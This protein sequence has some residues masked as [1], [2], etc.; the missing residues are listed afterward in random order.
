MKVFLVLIAVFIVAGLV[1]SNSPK[2]G[3]TTT[4]LGNSNKSPQT[5]SASFG[6][7]TSSRVDT[8]TKTPIPTAVPKTTPTP[9]PTKSARGK[10]LAEYVPSDPGVVPASGSTYQGGGV[11]ELA[12][13]LP[14]ATSVAVSGDGR[15]LDQPLPMC[16][17]AYPE[18]RTC[19]PYG[20]PFAQGCA[21]TPERNFT[22]LP[23]D[24][25][26]LDA[27]GDGIGCEPIGGSSPPVDA[28]VSASGPDDRPCNAAYPDVCIPAGPPYLDC[29][30]V[31]YLWGYEDFVVYPPDPQNFDGDGDGWG[32]EPYGGQQA[33]QSDWEQDFEEA[34]D[35]QREQ[36]Y[37]DYLDDQA[38][39]DDY[40]DDYYEEQ[41]DPMDY[42]DAHR[43]ME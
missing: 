32:C 13:S 37:Q 3:L 24:P 26:G 36:E 7:G 14:E 8:A 27:D 34:R 39:R 23:P 16:D 28:P 40:D 12:A 4:G 35:A 30:D 22:V 21:I 38:L 2:Q 43:C 6:S 20:P 11:A 19:I 42:C 15:L 1:Y 10:N 41:E 18:A 29:D 33:N 17:P 5:S 9:V 31:Y 25:Q